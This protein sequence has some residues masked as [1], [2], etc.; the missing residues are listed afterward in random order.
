MDTMPASLDFRCDDGRDLRVIPGMRERVL[1]Y[2]R[3]VSPRAEWT[4]EDY[5][6]AAAEKVRRGCRLIKT[7]REHFGSLE[8]AEIL[9]VGSLGQGPKAFSTATRSSMFTT[10]LPPGGV[11]SA[12]Q[13]AGGSGAGAEVVE[14]F[15]EVIDVYGPVAAGGG[16][17]SYTRR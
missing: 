8:G 5:A 2:R 1:H 4:D 11:M 9:E 14:E 7:I 12:S 3:S 13:A 15:D 6:A 10:P 16:D 17:I